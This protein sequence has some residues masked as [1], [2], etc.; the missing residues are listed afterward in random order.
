MSR[1]NARTATSDVTT[2]PSPS[3]SPPPLTKSFFRWCCFWTPFQL[4]SV[5]FGCPTYLLAACS[6]FPVA[7]WGA[8]TRR[9]PPPSD[10]PMGPPLHITGWIHTCAGPTKVTRSV[11]SGSIKFQTVAALNQPHTQ[12]SRRKQKGAKDARPHRQALQ[13]EGPN[14]GHFALFDRKRAGTTPEDAPL[15]AQQGHA[16]FPPVTVM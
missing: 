7:G 15:N 13:A 1:I 8:E 11:P 3:R 2:R 10:H 9:E 6:E 12:S 5:L 4:H 16:G 14:Q